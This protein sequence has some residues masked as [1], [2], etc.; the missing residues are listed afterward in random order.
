VVKYSR[1]WKKEPKKMP[2]LNTQ[3]RFEMTPP[4]GG[5]RAVVVGVSAGGMAA[6]STW[7][8]ALPKDFPL[9]VLVV[10]HRLSG[11]DD[12]LARSLD[13]ICAVRV[14]EAEEK[15]K[16]QPGCVYLAP[17]DYHLLVERDE[18]LSL[19]IDDKENYSRPSI[20]VLF[21]S[22]AYAWSERVIGIILTGA[23]SDGANGLALI[24]Q[25]GG[26]A[27]VQDP[28]TAEHDTMP[29]AAL[30]SADYVLSLPKIGELLKT[31]AR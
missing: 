23:N 4:P 12:Y 13:R 11:S 18:T 24:K 19:S 16:I 9:P 10:Q 22:A 7:L 29:R 14:K 28:Q 30:P 6:L 31:L 21:E 26:P 5:F 8:P 25:R 20:D 27:I 15:E 3:P 2:K 1:H 17:A